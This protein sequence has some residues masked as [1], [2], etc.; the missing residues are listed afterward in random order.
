MGLGFGR[1]LALGLLGTAP[2]QVVLVGF[3]LVWLVF[4]LVGWFF[5]CWFVFF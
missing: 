5:V 4:W 1:E 2:G 3:L